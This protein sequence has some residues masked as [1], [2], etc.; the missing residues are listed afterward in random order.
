MKTALKKQTAGARVVGRVPQLDPMAS[1]MTLWPLLVQVAG[2][3]RL[4]SVATRRVGLGRA[5]GAEPRG[6]E[7]IWQDC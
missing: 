6:N 4:N 2:P 5:C 7:G 3:A 1:P